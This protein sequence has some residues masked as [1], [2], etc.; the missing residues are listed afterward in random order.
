MGCVRSLGQG[1]CLSTALQALLFL[2]LRPSRAPRSLVT[3]TVPLE[4]MDSKYPPPGACL[5]PTYHT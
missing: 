5:P 3:F 1:L 4:D 2:E